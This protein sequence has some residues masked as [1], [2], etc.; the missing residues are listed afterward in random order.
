MFTCMSKLMIC[1]VEAGV[2]DSRVSSSMW[3][4]KL[5]WAAKVVFTELLWVDRAA[6]LMV[7]L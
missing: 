3:N 5:K 1:T 6:E 7:V 4:L 2:K